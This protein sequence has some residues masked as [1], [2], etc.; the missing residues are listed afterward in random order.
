MVAISGRAL[1]VTC[2]QDHDDPKKHRSPSA[3]AASIKVLHMLSVSLRVSRHS[4]RHRWRDAIAGT[5]HGWTRM[6]PTK[7]LA[8]MMSGT[9]GRRSA[10]AAARHVDANVLD[11]KAR[12]DEMLRAIATRRSAVSLKSLL[13]ILCKRDAS[14]K[15]C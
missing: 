3:F 1:V 14:V 12:A 11:A 13:L 2:C 8:S 4:L 9:R 6:Q 15:V 7:E 10:Y 5:R